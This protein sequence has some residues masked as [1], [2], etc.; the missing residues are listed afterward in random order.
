[1]RL[2]DVAREALA[3][4]NGQANL[5]LVAQ[6]AASRFQEV[7]S[8]YRLRHLRRVGE[9]IVPGAVTA[10]V[11][12]ATRGSSTVVGDATARTA[13][14]A[15]KAELDA[16][17][18]AFRGALAWYGV[19]G[20]DAA[21]D[22]RLATD[23]AEETTSVAGY[24]LVVRYVRLAD[25]VRFITAVGHP[26]LSRPLRDASLTRFADLDPQRRRVGVPELW[27]E[28]TPD[29]GGERRIEVYPYCALAEQLVYLYYPN[30]PRLGMQ[31]GLPPGI[32]G[33]LLKDGVLVD[34]FRWESAAAARAGNVELAGY[35]RN[36]ARAQETKWGRTMGLIA[37]ADQG[38]D[39]M[40]ML[41][42]LRP[43]EPDQPRGIYS[44]ADY[45]WHR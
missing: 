2:E 34:L 26:R 28:T 17:R 37:A 32:D 5:L 10:G 33:A 43:G 42:V 4:V 35:W 13:W 1:M 21:G 44:A 25:D 39:D 22:L 38:A 40:D 36:E 6:W 20:L 23:Y 24:H 16:G 7:A 45:V 41:L 29:P 31:D 12:T 15:I 3:A 9:V 27:V 11:A 19:A 18:R 14:A 30:P 8:Q